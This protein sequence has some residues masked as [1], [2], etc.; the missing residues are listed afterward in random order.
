MAEEKERVS[1]EV[2]AEERSAPS[3]R[4]VYKAIVSEGEEELA[5]PSSA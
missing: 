2:E 1:E 5:R 4:I 3:G